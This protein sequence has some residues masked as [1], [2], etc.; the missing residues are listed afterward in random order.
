MNLTSDHKIHLCGCFN[1]I[2]ERKF[3]D[4]RILIQEL[5]DTGF[6][7]IKWDNVSLRNLYPDVHLLIYSRKFRGFVL[8]RY[9]QDVDK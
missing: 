5:N 4:F 7:L 9:M 8:N 6:F 1:H 2:S 3:P